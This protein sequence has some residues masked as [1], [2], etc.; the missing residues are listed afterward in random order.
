MVCDSH[1]LAIRY[2]TSY[3]AV[4]IGLSMGTKSKT[5]RIAFSSYLALFIL[6][7][8]SVVFLYFPSPCICRKCSF[9]F[10]GAKIELLNL[11]LQIAR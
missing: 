11:A 10:A 5:D 8:A 7:S 9:S 3:D 1:C 6:N 2:V 4:R